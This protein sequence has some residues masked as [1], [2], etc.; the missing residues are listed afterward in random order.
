MHP[1]QGTG[2]EGQRRP[3]AILTAVL[4]AD[5][6]TKLLVAAR[7]PLGA[8]VTVIPGLLDLTHVHNPGVAFSLLAGVP[9]LVPA[10]IALTLLFLFFYN[11]ADWTRRPR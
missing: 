1:L 3:L 10:A 6:A 7:L 2:R 5:Q 9:L 11:E 4:A 8:S